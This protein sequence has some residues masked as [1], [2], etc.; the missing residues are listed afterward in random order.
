MVG[1]KEAK[2]YYQR[3]TKKKQALKRVDSAISNSKQSNTVRSQDTDNNLYL[4]KDDLLDSINKSCNDEF[5]I[6]KCPTL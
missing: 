1:K 4:T 2:A 5:T 6:K 3:N